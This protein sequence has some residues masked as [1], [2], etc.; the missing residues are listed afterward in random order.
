MRKLLAMLM[1]VAGLV[2]GTPTVVFA[3]CD[4]GSEND[5]GGTNIG[6]GC[7]ETGEDGGDGGDEGSLPGPYVP[8]GPPP[9]V[10]EDY[11]TPAC[12]ANGPPGQGNPDALCQGAVTIC[13]FRSDDPTAIYMQHW[14]REVPDG[15]WEFV[16]NECRG[17][18]D[19]T[20]E[21][22][23]VTQEM[24]LD[25]AYAAAPRPTAQVQPGTRSYV[26]VPNNYYADAPD[27]TITVN[28][29]GNPIAVQ[30]TVNEVAWD[31]GDG[32]TGSGEGVEDAD[33]GAPGSVEHAYTRQGDYTITATS[34]VGVRFTLPDGQ[35]VSLPNA[36]S[37]PGEPVTLPVGEI[38]TRVDSTN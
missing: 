30:F 24:V 4:Y 28:V 37:M 9:P 33:V 17:A 34:T 29:L 1:L 18:D 7:E 38:Q 2:V 14:R 21:Q 26:N 3:D 11:W 32:A 22:P 23:R 19:P 10:Y 16:G 12:S 5:G 8:T 25:E 35:T 31:F 6:G 27:S 13:E 36:F 20:T 15:T